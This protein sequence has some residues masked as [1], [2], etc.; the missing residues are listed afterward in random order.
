[1]R[2]IKPGF[3]AVALLFEAAVCVL[4]RLRLER[5]TLYSIRNYWGLSCLKSIYDMSQG[6]ICIQKSYFKIIL[7][8]GD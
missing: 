3:P 7:R 1:M 4:F 2:P 8:Y 5:P 6:F